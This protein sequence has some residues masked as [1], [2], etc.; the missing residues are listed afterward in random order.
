MRKYLIAGVSVLALGTGQAMAQSAI[1]NQDGT[2]GTATVTQTG[3]S[4]PTM[5]VEIDQAAGTDLNSATAT[6][7]GNGDGLIDIDQV[8]GN[9]N[10]ATAFQTDFAVF[11]DS[12]IF[13]EQGDGGE[14]TAVVNQSLDSNDATVTQ[15]GTNNTA[16]V[17]QFFAGGVT[18]TVTQSGQDNIAN[19]DQAVAFLSDATIVQE[20]ERGD[21]SIVQ[22]A[23]ISSTA[24]ISQLGTSTDAN[25]DIFQGPFGGHEATIIQTNIDGLGGDASISQLGVDQK[26]TI[27]QTG[28]VGAFADVN[29]T[30]SNNTATVTQ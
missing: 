10:S 21:A 12:N 30:G 20:G 16:T 29:Q 28:T 5:E 26:A 13:I 19:V 24:S 22:L 2:N 6:Q 4:G 7:I 11:G 15:N 25:A 14:H 18:A 1:V 9:N 3:A 17:D 8:G 23:E 27:T